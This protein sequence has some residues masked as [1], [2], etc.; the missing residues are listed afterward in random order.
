MSLQL[1]LT[2]AFAALLGALGLAALF[3]LDA[4]T[5][6]M[7]QA[8]GETA[9]SVG[10]RVF[11]LV[12]EE[13]AALVA[14]PDGEA[15]ARHEVETVV[16]RGA[17]DAQPGTAAATFEVVING[18]RLDPQQI[19]ALPADH[20]ARKA[21][22][23]SEQG[24]ARLADL[25]FRTEQGDQSMLWLHAADG[26]A[27]PIPIPATR[28]EI[29]IGDFRQRL[30]WGLGGLM[31]VGL[32]AAAWLARR[33]AAPLRELAE[34]SQRLGHGELAQRVRP[35]GPPEVRRSLE[36]FNRMA[37]DLARLQAEAEALRADREL[38][39]L[40]EIGRGLAHSLRNPLHALGLSLDALAGDHD[41]SRGEQLAAR[42]REQL[43]RID[44]AL[45]G[46]LALSASAGAA[47]EP[48]DLDELVDDVVLE[49]SQRAQGRV[50]F[51][52]QRTGLKLPGV[53]AEL[54]IVL[55]ALV[56]NALEASPDG[57][58][59]RIC[60]EPGQTGVRI[61][62]ADRGA[63]VPGAVRQRL[64]QPHVSTKPAGAGMGLYLAERL[65][66]LRYRGTLTL[67][68]RDGG[69]TLARLSL[70]PREARE[71]AA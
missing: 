49:A 50:S 32:L 70:Q 51:V 3:G 44:Q 63:G 58:E 21:L 31:L 20:P 71:A 42:G 39:E 66:R 25:E 55:H 4:L 6:D 37:D 35:G 69:G 53:A 54:R 43:A 27:L 30:L 62:I 8:L 40:G 15:G 22:Q 5:R 2:L 36:A 46:F 12:R 19:A 16:L 10:A 11:T 7:Q 48:V 34:A 9:R 59:V 38:A 52:R 26:R 24:A 56:I 29:A 65:V 18:Q 61:D 17:E 33:V 14:H 28:A 45:R 41:P 23:R 57:E 13:Q 1:R 67:E 60:V 68:D 47:V 64:F